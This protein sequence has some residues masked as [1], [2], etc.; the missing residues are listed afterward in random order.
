MLQAGPEV[1]TIG[2]SSL[3][4]AVSADRILLEF[5]LLNCTLVFQSA[6]AP[7]LEQQLISCLQHY[8]N[9]TGNLK[10]KHILSTNFRLIIQSMTKK[11]LFV[12]ILLIVSLTNSEACT[13]F[14]A[15]DKKG[16][17]WT[18]NNEDGIFSLN[19]CVNIVAPVNKT[20][21]YLYF[22][23]TKNSNEFPQGGLNDAGLFFD[24]NAVPVSVYK[25]FDNKKDFPNGSNEMMFFILRNC[26]TIQDVF[27]VFKTYRLKG[28]E[29]SQLHFADKYGTFG[30][31]VADSMWITKSNY[32]ISTNYNLCHPNKDSVDCWRF[33][34]AERIL[35]SREI[36]LDTFRDICD[37]ASQRKWTNYSN[38]QNL[39]T[40][41][42]WLYYAMN[43]SRPY[44]TNIHE[45]FKKGNGSFYMYELFKEDLLVKQLLQSK[46]T[47]NHFFVFILASLF[48]ILLLTIYIL[49]IRRRQRKL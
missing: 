3:S 9:V 16:S 37:S 43:Y 45:L 47:E 8:P 42:I 26:E 48:I 6:L 18:G 44:K 38:V 24:G 21:G 17:V 19:T 13:I 14:S 4:A 1:E 10:L 31:I 12:I 30:I 7:G 28:L 15:I 36:G 5:L 27:N 41:D 35:R 49:T 23:N 22:T 11:Y 20:F 39:N 33:P 2:C 25:D 34:I 46:E 40:G 32:Q 29:G